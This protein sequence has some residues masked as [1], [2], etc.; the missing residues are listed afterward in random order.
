MSIHKS[1]GHLY[2]GDDH[3]LIVQI[4]QGISDYYRSL[5][6]KH[7]EV[8]SPMWPAHITVVRTQKEIPTN[9]QFWKKYDYQ[10]I[11][12]YYSSIIDWDETYY[13]LDVYCKQLEFI[14]KELGL[15][16]VSQYT[17]PPSGFKKVFHTTIGNKK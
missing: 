17:L 5:I 10:P 1:I 13:W 7:M 4:D 15:S 14:R 12:F 9:L 8:S 6:P 3:K 2:Y 16:N 11:E